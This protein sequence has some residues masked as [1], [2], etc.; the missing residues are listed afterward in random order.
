MGPDQRATIMVVD[1][2]PSN[3]KVMDQILS[4]L[5]HRVFLFP[6]GDLFLDAAKK[7]PPDLVLMDINMPGMDGIETCRALRE[8]PGL[9]D[10]PVMFVS[11]VNTDEEKVNAFHA[12]GVDYITKPFSVKELTVRVN[13][14][15]SILRLRREL[16]DHN[17]R[18]EERIRQEVR[19]SEDAQLAMI[20]ALAKLAEVR[21]DHT[22]MHLERVRE[23]CRVLLQEVLNAGAFDGMLDEQ[24]VRYFPEASVLHDIG[25]V[26]L[27]DSVLLK[28]GRLT[29]EEFDQVKRHVEIGAV[30]LEEVARSFPDNPFVEMGILITRYHHE[31][32][33]GNG[34]LKG[35]KGEEIPLP[36]RLMAVVDVYD[37][38]RSQRPYKPPLSHHE[39]V[40]IMAEESEGQFD[41]KVLSCFLRGASKF[42]QIYQRFRD[43]T[44]QPG[45]P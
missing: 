34:Y 19:R 45:A 41:P 22:G 30:T 23:L 28:P 40:R 21:D 9:E 14:H 8:L 18:L 24:F 39:A 31:R 13:T 20:R 1:D 33:D 38:L 29:P 5:G 6:R 26:G 27:P 35:L 16:E 4:P 42:D 3:L 2:T 7:T 12:G 25:K 15:L 17:R 37:A 32:W 11:A 43:E 36:G 10:V 44:G